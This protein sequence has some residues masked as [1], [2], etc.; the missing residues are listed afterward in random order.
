MVHVAQPSLNKTSPQIKMV[1]TIVLLLWL[2]YWCIKLIR[3][4]DPT[5][6]WIFLDY[7]NL[8][9]HEA[10]HWLFMP[11]GQTLYI[12]GGSL[13]QLLL[14]A[15][16]TGYFLYHKD[17]LCAAFGTFWTGDNL[18]NVSYYVGDARSMSLPLLGGDSSIHDWN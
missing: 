14:P 11:F 18:V 3:L 4:Y 5:L 6:P 9:I 8:I 2:F 1:G 13:N 16:F 12:F 17:Y 15:I 7:L 10:G